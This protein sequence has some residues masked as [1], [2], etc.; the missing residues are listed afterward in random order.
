MRFVAFKCSEVLDDYVKNG[1]TLHGVNMLIFS[2]MLANTHTHT[3]THTHTQ[4]QNRN[5]LLFSINTVH[6]NIW[7]TKEMLKQS[8]Y[9]KQE[10]NGQWNS[11]NMLYK[12]PGLNNMGWE[13]WTYSSGSRKGQMKYG[14][15]KH[16]KTFLVYFLVRTRIWK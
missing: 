5:R 10:K 6:V 16:Y 14:N 3:H 7:A 8:H 11:T 12:Y 13:H 4:H 15:L 2:M 1:N 9:L